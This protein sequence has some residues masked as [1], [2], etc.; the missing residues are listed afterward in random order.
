MRIGVLG[1]GQVGQTLATGLLRLGHEVKVGTRDTAKLADWLKKTNNAK[2]S[3]GSFKEAAGFGE[4]VVL[5]VHGVASTN[6]IDLAGKEN[7]KGKIVM[8]VTN[9]LDSS[10]GAPRFA[11]TLGRSLGQQIQRHIPDARVVKAFNIVNCYIMINPK[12]QEGTPD[13]FI[14]GDDKEAKKWVTDLATA[15]GWN[16]C[17]D[18]GD[19]EQSY[20]LETFAMLWIRY[21][22]VNNH[23]TH[24]FKLLKN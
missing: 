16:S 1:S 5:A 7:F 21:G 22:I 10:Q 8:D 17:N 9:P 23:W 24:A 15:W 13:M 12:M 2:A 3:V 11:S 4:V 14:A 19:L 18:L 20:W 6:A